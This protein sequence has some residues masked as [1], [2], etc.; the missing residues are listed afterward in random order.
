MV[1]AARRAAYTTVGVT[2]AQQKGAGGGVADQLSG[3]ALALLHAQTQ[4]LQGTGYDNE[5][6]I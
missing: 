4:T 3:F 1:W 6:I 2:R 5:V